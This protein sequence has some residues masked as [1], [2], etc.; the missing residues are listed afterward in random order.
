MAFEGAIEDRLAVRERIDAYCDAVFRRDPE[1]WIA[2]W[3]E[4]ATWSLPGLKVTGKDE[5]KALWIQAMEGFSLAAF[6]AAPGHIRIEGGRAEARVY[7]QEILVGRDGKV[8]RVV[9]TYD[10][11]L[12]KQAGTWL[13]ASRAYTILHQEPQEA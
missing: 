5:I 8:R 9:G 10:D 4:D 6:F 3:T 13:F 2:N 7:I 11:A 12:V 1:A